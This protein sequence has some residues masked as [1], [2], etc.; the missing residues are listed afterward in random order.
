MVVAAGAEAACACTGGTGNGLEGEGAGRN[1]V[2]LPS[3][4]GPRAASKCGVASSTRDGNWIGCA[5]D[6][7]GRA[8]GAT[9]RESP[10]DCGIGVGAAG[11]EGA[12]GSVTGGAD[13][14]GVNASPGGGGARRV[15]GT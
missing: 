5:G 13:M 8:G 10:P 6:T 11:A 7:S 9:R 15:D 1:G 2:T 12:A 14:P 3:C 4:R